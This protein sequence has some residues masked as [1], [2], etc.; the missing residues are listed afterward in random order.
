MTVQRLSIVE[1]RSRRARPTGTSRSR[2][3]GVAYPATAR[4]ELERLRR[5]LRSALQ[6][7]M[8]SDYFLG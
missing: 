3:P 1:P 7:A 5:L 6:T 4:R 8:P 2:G